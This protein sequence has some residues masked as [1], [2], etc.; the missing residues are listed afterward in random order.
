MRSN[1]KRRRLRRRNPGLKVLLTTGYGEQ[2]EAREDGEECLAKPFSSEELLGRV[3]KLIGDGSS[4][5]AGPLAA[6]EGVQDL[7]GNF[8]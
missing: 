6:A 7:A 3:K 5:T 4:R 1:G 2:M 8:V